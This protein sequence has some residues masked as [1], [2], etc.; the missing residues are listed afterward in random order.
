M[1]PKMIIAA[2]ASLV[3]IVLKMLAVP[4]IL[5][6]LRGYGASGVY[7]AYGVLGAYRPCGAYGA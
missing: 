7:D 1:V 4:K 5:C 3:P 6:C 2:M